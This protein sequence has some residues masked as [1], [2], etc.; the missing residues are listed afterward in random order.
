M[1]LGS[2]GGVVPA[3]GETLELEKGFVGPESRRNGEA[4]RAYLALKIADIVVVVFCG[5]DS[6]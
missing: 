3:L 2:I 1:P 4:L 5:C 6:E